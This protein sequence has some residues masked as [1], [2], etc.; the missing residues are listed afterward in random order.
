MVS[1]HCNTNGRSVWTIRCQKYTWFSHKPWEDLGQLWT[2]QPPLIYK[3]ELKYLEVRFLSFSLE[4][5][6][7][8]CLSSE[9]SLVMFWK[10]HYPGDKIKV[11]RENRY[12]WFTSGISNWKI[13]LSAWEQEKVKKNYFRV[14][15]SV[16]KKQ[17][18]ERCKNMSLKSTDVQFLDVSNNIKNGSLKQYFSKYNSVQML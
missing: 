13:T 10:F 18:K 8:L 9:Y 4:I 16:Y 17:P 2:F 11:W 15:L 1:K 5:C 6:D 12:F 14:Y 7:F 3:N